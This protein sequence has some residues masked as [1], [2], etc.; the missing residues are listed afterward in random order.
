MNRLAT[1]HNTFRHEDIID[2]GAILSYSLPGT[3][4]KLFTMDVYST[5][6]KK[7]NGN[8][9]ENFMTDKYSE[10]THALPVLDVTASHAALTFIYDW[11]M[12]PACPTSS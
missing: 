8:Q 12:P 7:T 4:L 6:P 9:S 5:L 11:F 2:I 1:A 10:L 3:P